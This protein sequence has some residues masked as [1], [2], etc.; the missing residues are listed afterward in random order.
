[1]INVDVAGPRSLTPL[2]WRAGEWTEPPI[3]I[4]VN[5]DDGAI[6]AVQVVLQDEWAGMRV[7]PSSQDAVSGLPLVAFAD[8]PT[9]GYWDVRCRVAVARAGTGELIVDLGDRGAVSYAGQLGSLLFGWDASGELC[10]IVIGP[11]SSEDWD[12]V[13]AFSGDVGSA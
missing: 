4:E 13:N 11:L 1:L 3:D 2:H 12:D 5:P 9:D 8:W 6:Q 10:Q 7:P